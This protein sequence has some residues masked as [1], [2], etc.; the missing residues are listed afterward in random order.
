MKGSLWLPLGKQVCEVTA[1]SVRKNHAKNGIW[2]CGT[3]R[4]S[5]FRT[6]PFARPIQW[7]ILG[8]GFTPNI[9]IEPVQVRLQQGAL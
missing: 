6:L 8:D 9:Q 7:R 5:L 1:S 2:P 3:I 4:K